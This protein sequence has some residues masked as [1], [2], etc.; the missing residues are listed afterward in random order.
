MHKTLPPIV[1][2][3][4]TENDDGTMSVRLDVSDEF[5]EWFL[6]TEGLEEWDDDYFQDWFIEAIRETL[7]AESEDTEETP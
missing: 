5:I 1:V 4:T 7:D 3:D 6:E 2:I